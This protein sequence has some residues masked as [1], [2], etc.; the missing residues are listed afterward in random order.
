LKPSGSNTTKQSPAVEYARREVKS[1]LEKAHGT[2]SHWIVEVGLR[3][4][5]QLSKE[6]ATA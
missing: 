4:N 3:L 2:I 1:A 6:A 5:D